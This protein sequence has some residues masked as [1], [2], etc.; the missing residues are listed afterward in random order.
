M[1]TLKLVVIHG[2]N[3]NRLGKRD[4]ARYGSK[5]LA[6]V[7]ADIEAA[8]QDLNAQVEVVQSNHEGDLVDWLHE[9]V[10]EIDGIV[11]NPAS[12]TPYGRSLAQAV[13]ESGLPVAVVHISSVYKTAKPGR[14]DLFAEVADAVITGIGTH[15]YTVALE[16]LARICPKH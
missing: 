8:A 15:G 11:I 2:P 14:V 16:H 6:E 9:R 7:N 5:T 3:L 12:L 1:T 10:D 4:P 13:G